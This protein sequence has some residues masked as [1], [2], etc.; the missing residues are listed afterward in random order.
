MKVTKR[1][2]V[3][4][5]T[6]VGIGTGAWAD[7]TPDGAFTINSDGDQVVFS[8]GNLQYQ[9]STNTWRFAENQ[10]DYIGNAAGN[11]SPSDS[12]TAWIDYFNWGTSGYNH[13]ANCYQPWSTSTS[14]S[15]YYAYGSSSKNLY[16]AKDDDSMRGQADWGYNAISNGGNTE[17]SGWRTLTK[18]EWAYIMTSRTDSYKYAKGTIH[19]TNGLILFPDGFTPPSGISISNANTADAGYT[20]Y[21]DTDWSALEAAGCVFLPATGL[22][23]GTKID[24]VGSVGNYWSGTY[25]NGDRVYNIRFDGSSLKLENDGD[26]QNG[27]PVRLVKKYSSLEQDADGYYLLGS[28]QNW[29]DFAEIVNSGTN[30]AANARMTADIDLGDD[31]TYISPTWYGEFSDKH[32]HGTFDG[33]GYTLTV[34]YSSSNMWHTPFSQTSGATIMNLH[35]AGTITSTSSEPSHMSGLISNSAGND[36]IKNVWVSAAITGGN[37]SWIECGAFVGC[38]NCGNTTITDCLFTG[39]ITTAG[40]HNGCFA[41]WVQSYSPSSI[42]TTNCLSVGTFSLGSDNS[43]SRGTL[44]NCYIKSYPASIP[45]EM[46]IRDAQL[47]DG[48]IAYKLQGGRADLVWGQRIGIDEEPVLTNDESYRVYKSKNGGY[49]N[50]PDEAYLGSLQKDETDGYYLIGNVWD[51][52]AFADIINSGE[53]ASA[54]AKMTADIDLG[55]DQTMIGCTSSTPY[56]GTFDG[57]GHMLTVN[58]NATGKY[59]AVFRYVNGAT[60]QGVHVEGS[61]H[62]D[63]VGL[64]GL[65]G[66]GPNTTVRQCW[67]SAY[68]I[69]DEV[70]GGE[71]HSI[72]GIFSEPGESGLMEDCLFDGTIAEQN[73]HFCGGFSNYSRSAV[74]IRNSLNLGTFPVADSYYSSETATFIRT[75]AG[76]GGSH[77][78]ENLFYLNSFGIPQGTQVTAETLADESVTMA[79]NADRTGDE[80][81]WVQQGD[82]PMLKVFASEGGIIT[83]IDNGQRSK[84]IGQR[85]GWYTIDGRKLYGKPMKKG[86]YI[87][88]GNKVVIK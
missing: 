54:N 53:N 22:R 31:Q 35:V 29:I 39:S 50:D 68:L 36:V 13:G 65:V 62:S 40:G 63:R 15:N 23:N 44:S 12:Q 79:L 81:P 28:V 52:I 59:V 4:M 80:A 30:T 19:N 66:S 49:T 64:G 24:E 67:V 60:I 32:Y 8:K 5:L 7:G 55:D 21:S 75:D 37:N 9:A 84:G 14:R 57:Q 45:Y 83:G 33:Q 87:N 69:T 6:L 71:R 20:S 43:V 18:D 11:T 58:I 2:L 25:M 86:I 42:T 1:I 46:Q 56:Q 73:N 70:G 76:A 38:N 61:L 88:N 3:I 82:Q 77:V 17:N 41:G 78:L 10:Y 51:W 85:D 26:R 16:D 48:T 47:A 27:F 74:T 72:G 34:H